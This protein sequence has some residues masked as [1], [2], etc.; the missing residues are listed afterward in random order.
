MPSTPAVVDVAK[1]CPSV[2]DGAPHVCSRCTSGCRPSLNRHTDSL[3]SLDA[4]HRQGTREVFGNRE[5]T[6][7]GAAHAQSSSYSI[8]RERVLLGD[9]YQEPAEG[10]V[11]ANYR[12]ALCRLI[13]CARTT[14]A[15]GYRA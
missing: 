8:S 6:A 13:Y 11:S 14:R 3:A 10:L 9:R 12:R 5:R 7:A 4:L 2:I 1:P 15:F